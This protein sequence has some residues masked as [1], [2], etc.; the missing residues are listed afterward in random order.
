MLVR[1]NSWTYAKVCAHVAIDRIGVDIVKL[2]EDFKCVAEVFH[3][4]GLVSSVRQGDS[5]SIVDELSSHLAW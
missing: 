2:N 4:T 3:R 5:A 1:W